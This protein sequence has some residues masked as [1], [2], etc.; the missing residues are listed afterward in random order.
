MIQVEEVS[1]QFGDRILFDD[2]NLTLSTQY[3]YILVGANGAGK[4]SFLTLITGEATP[5]LG[6]ITVSKSSKIGWM[7]QKIHEY[8]EQPLVDV[9]IQGKEALWKAMEEKNTLLES[10]QWGDKESNKLAKLEERI[11]RQGGYRAHADAEALLIG[12]GFSTDEH[13]KLLKQFSGGWKMRVLLAQL[14]FDSPDILLLD[15][16]T[17]YLDIASI[18]WLENYLINSYQGLLLVISHDQ[19]FLQKIGTCVLD[20]DYG[21]ILQ[22][23]GTYDQFLR[24]KEEIALLKEKEYA[25]T[26]ARVDKMQHFVDRFRGKATK[27][28]QA[29]SRMKMI[30]KVKWPEL[31]RSSR[32]SPQFRFLQN[33]RTGQIPFKAKEL[34]KIFDPDILIGPLNLEL[35]RGERIAFIGKNG[36]GKTTL[37]KLLTEQLLPDYGSVQIHHQV[38]MAIFHQE[39]KH[40]FTGK[41]TVLEWLE[42]EA[43][44]INEEK[45]RQVLGQLLFRAEE[46]NKKITMLSGGEMAR[47]LLAKIMLA[48]ANALILDEPTNHLD[49]ESTDAL[50]QALIQYEGTVIFVSH[51]RQFIEKVSTRTIE[52][53]RELVKELPYTKPKK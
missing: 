28:K 6:T 2:V 3:R 30:E 26:Q 34:C 16:P 8:D 11:D 21:Q 19:Q 47:L 37:I 33:K 17:N 27:A 51:D 29:M 44:H 42:N 31:G 10:P 48:K 49:I 5:T 45:R 41:E 38:E 35:H 18:A 39:H 24:K 15:E 40:L 4:S 7:R 32:I 14:L 1:L 20:V 53:N 12:L 22:Y 25:Q 36:G 46:V 52:V 13:Q 50:A 23:P 9:V 43:S